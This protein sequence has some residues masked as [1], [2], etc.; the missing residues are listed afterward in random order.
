MASHTGPDTSAAPAHDG[1]MS[2]EPEPV[3]S[4][5]ALQAREQRH[6]RRV[7]FDPERRVIGVSGYALHLD[8]ATNAVALLAWIIEVAHRVN[9]QRV[10]DIIGELDDACQMV[11]GKSLQEVYC[12]QGEPRFVDW[13]HRV[14]RPAR[15]QA[16]EDG[17]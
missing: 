1:R 10:C 11:F 5:I 4:E 8:A 2:G 9:P 16:M 14:I 17:A 13:R 7:R 6:R 3:L 15:L 12:P